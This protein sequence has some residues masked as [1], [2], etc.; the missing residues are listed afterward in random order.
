LAG[1]G[2]SLAADDRRDRIDF[3]GIYRIHR[4]GLRCNRGGREQETRLVSRQG[5]VLD[6]EGRP[7][8]YDL[9]RQRGTPVYYVFD[10]LWMNGKDLR[11]LPLDERKRRLRRI[12]PEQPSVLLYA[13]HIERSGTEFFRL[14]CER[15][16]EG[17]VAKL[18]YGKYGAGR[19]KIRNQRY[20]QY[21]GRRE[22][23]EKRFS[24]D[25]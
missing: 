5:N 23:F 22:L 16:L 1:H 20:S 2:S 9:L 10:V 25:V 17:T 11:S 3:P 12:V 13:D 19:Y 21:E 14:A 18:R 4:P 24:A 7:Q 8:F 15:D 6:S